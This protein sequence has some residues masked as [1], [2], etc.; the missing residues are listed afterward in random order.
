MKNIFIVSVNSDIAAHIVKN[1]K[2]KKWNIYGTYRKGGTKIFNF[3]NKK[4]FIKLDLSK[5]KFNLNKINKFIKKLPRID[6]FTCLSQTQKPFGKFYK[7][8]FDEWENSFFINFLNPVKI[9]RNVYKRLSS[10]SSVI[11]FTGGGPNKATENFSGYALAK[12]LYIKFTELLAAEDKK[13]KFAC[14][15]PGWVKTKAHDIFL[16][17]T[18][19]RNTS[20]YIKLKKKIKEGSFVNPQLTVD[21]FNWFYEKKNQNLS[22]RYYVLDYDKFYYKNFEKNLNKN[23]NFLR[24]RRFEIT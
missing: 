16:K 7:I 13:I 15:N 17:Q 1:Y 14:I 24:F 21:F 18:N 2:N 3:L 4:N 19:L 8:N 23:I 10:Q 22:G 20:D 12:F 11:F 9:L 6:I 5:K